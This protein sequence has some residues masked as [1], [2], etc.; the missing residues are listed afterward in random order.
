MNVKERSPNPR[1]T[2]TPRAHV[3]RNGTALVNCC[4]NLVRCNAMFIFLTL[5]MIQGQAVANQA[6]NP[7]RQSEAQ[8][9]AETD[10]VSD[11][12]GRSTPHGT[13][14]GF[15]QAAQSGHYKE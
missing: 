11:P 14:F 9:S 1:E 2:N 3:V 4:R 13:V 5:S 15:L 6:G 7:P 12:L 8:T 10:E